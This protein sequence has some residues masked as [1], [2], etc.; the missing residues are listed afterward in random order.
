MQ[1][2]NLPEIPT[3]STTCYIYVT[4]RRAGA[5]TAYQVGYSAD[6]DSGSRLAAAEGVV[7]MRP[8]SDPID[9]LGH[10]LLLEQLSD[11]S[12]RRLIRNYNNKP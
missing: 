5:R 3:R 12:L 1:K 7:Y 10:K 9:A 2:M 8:F 6:M 11:A 4:R